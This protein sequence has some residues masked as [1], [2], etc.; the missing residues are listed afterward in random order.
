[1]SKLWARK[2]GKKIQLL[3]REEDR[4]PFTNLP[5]ASLSFVVSLYLHGCVPACLSVWEQFIPQWTDIRELFI[6]VLLKSV[7]KF[8]FG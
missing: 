4:C 2:R 8:G 3:I 7:A 1:M 5:E 6:D